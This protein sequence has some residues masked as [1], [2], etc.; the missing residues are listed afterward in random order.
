MR[1]G[2]LLTLV[3]LLWQPV[4]TAAQATTTVF[5]V[6]HAERASADTDSPLSDV[7]RTRATALAHSLGKAGITA[8]F[9]SQFKRTQETAAPLAAAT[10][11]PA[12]TVDARDQEALVTAI[13]ALPAGSRVVV[14][15]HSNLVPVIATRLSGQAVPAMTEGE[16]DWLYQ[17][18]MTAPGSGT[19]IPLRYGGPS[20]AH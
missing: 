12:Q 14:V 4:P 19:V 5:V 9:T 18:T 11:V 10:G 20:G 3:G 17:V 16:F 2:L 7:G 8:I 13:A 6:R 15:S 1:F